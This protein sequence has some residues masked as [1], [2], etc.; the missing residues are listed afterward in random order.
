MNVSQEI[1]NTLAKSGDRMSVAEIADAIGGLADKS[2]VQAICIQ[3]TKKGAFGR[4][5]EEGRMVYWM[6]N[7]DAAPA[8]DIGPLDEPTADV[9]KVAQPE[10]A[11]AAALPAKVEEL[12]PAPPKVIQEEVR[13]AVERVGKQPATRP[14]SAPTTTT[15]CELPD[16]AS[17]EATHQARLVK[18]AMHTS[19]S[20]TRTLTHL[21]DDAI[22]ARMEH[23][24]LAR[25][26]T[27]Q[28]A[29]QDVYAFLMQQA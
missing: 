17:I 22:E 2:F 13:V 6:V 8:A 4:A 3:H 21:M 5:M 26:C 18:R 9:P 15:A 10:V 24:A 11:V 7:P 20:L 29:I 25:I 27:A 1:R 23:E 16:S 14:R 28:Q 12:A 19:H